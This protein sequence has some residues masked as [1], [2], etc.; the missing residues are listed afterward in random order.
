MKKDMPLNYEKLSPK[1]IFI[2]TCICVP[3]LFILLFG[4][5]WFCATH[6]T[7]GAGFII[8]ASIGVVLS[9]V[10]AV[11]QLI[12]TYKAWKDDEDFY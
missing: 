5:L 4:T 1:G 8:K 7:L 3:I 12:T 11:W 2:R 6:F 10:V 9:I